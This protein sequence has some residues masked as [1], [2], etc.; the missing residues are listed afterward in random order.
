MFKSWKTK[1]KGEFMDINNFKIG[2]KSL[3]SYWKKIY[4]WK[5]YIMSIRNCHPWMKLNFFFEEPNHLASLPFQNINGP[6]WVLSHLP[7]L[8]V[9]VSELRFLLDSMRLR[10]SWGHETFQKFCWTFITVARINILINTTCM[11]VCKTLI[12]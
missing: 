7:S 9:L 12:V 11:G 10:I 1:K 4:F 2:Q 3:F 6:N 5:H 8:P